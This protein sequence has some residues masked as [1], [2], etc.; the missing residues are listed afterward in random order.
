MFNATFKNNGFK[1]ETYI[2]NDGGA[3]RN[4]GQME[5]QQSWLNLI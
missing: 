4:D 3:I 2:V 5:I 1:D